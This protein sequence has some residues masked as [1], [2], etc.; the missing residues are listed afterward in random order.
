MLDGAGLAGMTLV[1][2]DD[3]PPFDETI[4]SGATFEENALLKARDGAIF[5]ADGKLGLLRVEYR[6][7]AHELDIDHA[8]KPDQ[9]DLAQNFTIQGL[10]EPPRVRL[11]GKPAQVTR[12]GNYFW[13]AL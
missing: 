3:V 12:N 11:N 7:S 13:V 8:P 10:A 9:L 2:L 1:S 5:G 4:E 6:P